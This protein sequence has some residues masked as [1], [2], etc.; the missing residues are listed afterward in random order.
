MKLNVSIAGFYAK[1]PTTLQNTHREPDGGGDASS[2]PSDPP[3]GPEDSGPPVPPNAQ[4]GIGM[5]QNENGFRFVF[6][7]ELRIFFRGLRDRRQPG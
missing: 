1:F 3:G 7:V 4:N 6:D 5:E 2:A